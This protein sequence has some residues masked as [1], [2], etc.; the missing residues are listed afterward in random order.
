M[1]DLDM[2]FLAKLESSEFGKEAI[3]TLEEGVFSSSTHAVAR[4]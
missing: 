4:G 1:K 3:A 2:S